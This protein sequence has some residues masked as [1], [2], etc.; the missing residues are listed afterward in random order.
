MM[1][2]FDELNEISKLSKG[3]AD[4]P[5]GRIIWQALGMEKETFAENMRTGLCDALDVSLA[6]ICA[7]VTDWGLS[8]AP[9]AAANCERLAIYGPR[10]SSEFFKAG[11]DL[12]ALARQDWE[13]A[14]RESNWWVS[15]RLKVTPKGQVSPYDLANFFFQMAERF[16]EVSNLAK[17]WLEEFKEQKFSVLAGY[18]LYHR[19]TQ[20]FKVHE[21]SSL[22]VG[23]RYLNPSD[24]RDYTVAI[25]LLLVF[26]R[27]DVIEK[28]LHFR[29]SNQ[30]STS[31]ISHRYVKLGGEQHVLESFVKASLD[32]S[33]QMVANAPFLTGARQVVAEEN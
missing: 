20:Q 1:N 19:L 17:Q 23:D 4:S 8:A 15:E 12:S 10:L 13:G 16:S 30:V 2:E 25:T 33:W 18:T 3:I 27:P 7:K 9:Q 22:K 11:A 29:L 31:V 14:L 32:K 26:R 5:L 28:G 6:S 24:P 21:L